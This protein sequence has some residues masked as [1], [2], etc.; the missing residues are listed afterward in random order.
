MESSA[1]VTSNAA[2]KSKHREQHDDAGNKHAVGQHNGAAFRQRTSSHASMH[3]LHGGRSSCQHASRSCTAAQPPSGFHNCA[4]HGHDSTLHG[5]H[6]TR[7]D[8]HSTDIP[9]HSTRC[10]SKRVLCAMALQR[11]R[12]SG[13][14]TLATVLVVIAVAAGLGSSSSSVTAVR[15]LMAGAVQETTAPGQPQQQRS[16]LEVFTAAKPATCD[17]GIVFGGGYNASDALLLRPQSSSSSSSRGDSRPG[18]GSWLQL[19]QLPR[20][21]QVSCNI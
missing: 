1:Q 21:S 17:D 14:C 8:C 12:R 4:A 5:C 7:R 20:V 19:S 18:R 2:S 3:E 10:S 9:P 11:G 16:Q 13:S 6:S 15:P